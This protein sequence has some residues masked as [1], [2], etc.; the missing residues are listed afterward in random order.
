MSE[1]RPQELQTFLTQAADILVMNMMLRHDDRWNTKLA[2]DP[3]RKRRLQGWDCA[4]VPWNINDEGHRF[5]LFK[6]LGVE[7]VR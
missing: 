3:D 5:K 7:G 4:G 6:M 2:Q 1:E